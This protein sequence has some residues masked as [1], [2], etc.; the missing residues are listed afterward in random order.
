M[1]KFAPDL[2]VVV[3]ENAAGKSAIVDALRLVTFPA[4]GRQS[5]WFSG[6]VCCMIR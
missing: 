3:G 4:S 1:V 2:T 6:G 5:A